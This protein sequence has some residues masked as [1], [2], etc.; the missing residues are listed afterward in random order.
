[1]KRIFLFNCFYELK[2]I[3]FSILSFQVN[4]LFWKRHLFGVQRNVG[5]AAELS[6]TCLVPQ[7]KPFGPSEPQYVVSIKKRCLKYVNCEADPKKWQI[8]FVLV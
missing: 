4:V 8:L 1:M 2:V 7:N 5:F 3:F 6:F